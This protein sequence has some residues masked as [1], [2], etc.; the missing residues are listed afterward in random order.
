MSFH[1]NALKKDVSKYVLLTGDPLRAKYIAYKYLKN[2]HQINNVRNMSMYTGEYKNVKITVAGGGMGNP[3]TAIYSHEFFKDYD[4]D[5]IIRLGTCGSYDRKIDNNDIVNVKNARGDRN[6]AK[7]LANLDTDLVTSSSK[8]FQV[9]NDVAKKENIKVLNEDVYASHCFYF[10]DPLKWKEVKHKYNVKVV[11]MDS[12]AL[13]CNAKLFNKDAASIL[14]V[15]DS[16]YHDVAL[17]SEYKERNLDKMGYL[18]LET[19]VEYAK[20]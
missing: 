3:S 2:F 5:L 12:F 18:G 1:I 4:C 9:I 10:Y 8:P 13:F 6:F 11:S 14:T 7:D 17:S 20:K 15:V 16:F 19:V